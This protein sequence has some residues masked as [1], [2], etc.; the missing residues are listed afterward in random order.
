MEKKVLAMLK[1]WLVNEI[2]NLEEDSG[3]FFDKMQYHKEEFENKIEALKDVLF[4]IVKTES[5]IDLK[6]GE[7]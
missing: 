1:R 6:G 5:D 7:E 2:A 4:Y 3:A